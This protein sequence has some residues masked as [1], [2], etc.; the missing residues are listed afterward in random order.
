MHGAT[1]QL[2]EKIITLEAFWTSPWSTPLPL[3]SL[4][5]TTTYFLFIIP[6]LSITVLSTNECVYAEIILFSFMFLNIDDSML[7]LWFAFF[8]YFN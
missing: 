2:K 3:P 5:E 8:L 7:Y 6:S 1:T 4:P